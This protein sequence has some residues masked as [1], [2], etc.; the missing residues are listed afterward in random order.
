MLEIERKYLIFDM[1]DE[2]SR[3]D[4]QTITQA[5]LNRKPVLRIRQYGAHYFLTYKGPGLAVRQEVELRI[6]PAMYE[7]LLPLAGGRII[8]KIRYRIPYGTYMI[9]LDIFRDMPTALCLAEIEF[10]STTAMNTC[11]TPAWFGP[12]VTE[13]PFFQNV[14]LAHTDDASFIEK[15]SAYEKGYRNEHE[16]TSDPG[17]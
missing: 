7:R 5:Y 6:T 11:S 14:N 9:D 17:I 15:L 16:G 1:P 10:P 4:G 13:D 3:I 12:D 8:R 2:V